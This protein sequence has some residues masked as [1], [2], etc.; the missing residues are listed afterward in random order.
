ML[1]RDLLFEGLG[2]LLF[3]AD[4]LELG[5]REGLASHNAR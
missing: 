1:L 3:E 2:Y 5:L 4:R